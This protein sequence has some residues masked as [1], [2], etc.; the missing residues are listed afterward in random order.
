M[1]GR[2]REA[3]KHQS[4]TLEDWRNLKINGICDIRGFD[5]NT[6]ALESGNGRIYV[7]G[8]GLKIESLEKEGGVVVISGEI[9]GVFKAAS[10]KGKR[11]F[12]GK[13][14]GG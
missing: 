8:T 6:V 1:E 2:E 5:E 9:S 10:E 4:L 7:E 11:G 3:K 14:F 12:F 13:L